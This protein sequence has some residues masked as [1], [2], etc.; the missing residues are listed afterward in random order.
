[1]DFQ[2]N[3]SFHAPIS[4]WQNNFS[5]DSSK[6]G[7]KLFDCATDF[8]AWYMSW[9]NSPSNH[10]Q[11]FRVLSQIMRIAQVS[12][13]GGNY[14]SDKQENQALASL[15]HLKEHL[16]DGHMKTDEI[17]SNL[18]DVLQTLIIDNPK[19]RVIAH[20]TEMEYVFCIHPPPSSSTAASEDL[21]QYLAMVIQNVNPSLLD[22]HA[23]GIAQSMAKILEEASSIADPKQALE[24]A[25]GKWL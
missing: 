11:T 19:A 25:I 2:I 1:M 21:Q 23:Y 13:D 6:I 10:S 22:I 7:Q 24:N 18:T 12:V 9:D 3:N 8:Y 5:A 15:G 14:L 16:F 17:L 20:A 4:P